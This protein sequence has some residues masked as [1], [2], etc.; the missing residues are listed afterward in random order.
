MKEI[1]FNEDNLT[2]KDINEE[3]T[4]VKALIINSNDEIMLGY[5]NKTYQFPGGHL[6]DGETFIECL[7]REVMEETGILIDDNE[8]KEPASKVGSEIAITDEGLIKD[9]DDLGTT[10]YFRGKVL[11]NYVTFANMLWRIVRINGDNSIRLVLDSELET[12]SSYYLN[13]S[14]KFDYNSSNI[15]ETLITWYQEKLEPY[16]KYIVNTKYC[17]DIIH[18]EQHNFNTYTRLFINKI[19]TF[20]CLGTSIDSNIGLL[21]ADE[22]VFAGGIMGQANREYY[23]Y[24]DSN[25]P[26]YTMS[27]AK[28]DGTY[29]NMFMLDVD[30]SLSTIVNGNLFRNVKPVIS[31]VKMISFS[32]NGTKDNPYVIETN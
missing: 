4:R 9:S 13:E 25:L 17:S 27:G 10:Y 14:P 18:D 21:T 28:G 24:S 1:V 3:V 16:T 23:L 2:D 8:I 31:I 15:K 19:P 20:N 7:K 11:N 32:G 5:S 6:E 12:V 30:G 29:I 22:I 26:I